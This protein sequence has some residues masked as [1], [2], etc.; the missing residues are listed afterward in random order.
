MVFFVDPQGVQ[1]FMGCALLYY[2]WPDD[3]EWLPIETRTVEGW[4]VI[5]VPGPTGIHVL[6]CP[7]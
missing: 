6:V 7:D 2:S 1:H 3:P 4:F 5:G